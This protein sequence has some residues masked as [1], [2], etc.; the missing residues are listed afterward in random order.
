MPVT[1]PSITQN[2]TQE[3]FDLQ[4][5]RNQI[6][7]HKTRFQFGVNTAVGTT[8]ETL[9]TASSVY[10]YLAAATVIKI[11]SG[12]AS[13]ASAGTGARTV[14]IEGL[15]ADYNEVSETVSLNGQ[16]AVNTVNSYL[17]IFDI[18]VL[19]AGSGGAAAGVIYAGTGAVTTGVPAVVYAEIP[20]GY[21]KSQMAIWTVPA[22]Y[23]AYITSYAFTTASATANNIVTGAMAIRPFGGVFSFEATAKIGGGNTWDR[24][25]DTYLVVPEKADIELQGAA[26]A[27]A[28][29]TGEIQIIY[30]QNDVA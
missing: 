8:F 23:T 5:S 13:D 20:V 3:P 27:A 10:S 11:S 28:Q 30:I 7:W 4:V 2:G 6:S 12:S 17:R 1:A 15:D 19:T 29:A 25:F 22:G 18:L 9:W 26:T 24:H 16:T 14:L 21:G